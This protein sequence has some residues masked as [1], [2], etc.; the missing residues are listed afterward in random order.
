MFKKGLKEYFHIESLKGQ[1]EALFTVLS[2]ISP[3]IFKIF[4]EEKQIKTSR[5][6]YFSR[7]YFHMPLVEVHWE[8]L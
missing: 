5:L 8:H 4:Y 6:L 1:I 2:Y 3:M 7:K